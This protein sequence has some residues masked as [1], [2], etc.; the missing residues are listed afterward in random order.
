MPLGNQRRPLSVERSKRPHFKS[1]VPRCLPIVYT[2][3]TVYRSRC[4]SCRL[5]GLRARSCCAT[6]E[7]DRQWI[8]MQVPLCF[9]RGDKRSY[10]NSATLRGSGWRLLRNAAGTFQRTATPQP[11]SYGVRAL[12]EKTLLHLLCKM[13]LLPSEISRIL[14]RGFYLHS[15]QFVS[16]P[17]SVLLKP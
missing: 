13:K 4:H 1:L 16:E 8:T 5:R 12:V 6:E 3:R 15:S 11:V 7:Y 10:K 17:S 9:P 14:E 2:A